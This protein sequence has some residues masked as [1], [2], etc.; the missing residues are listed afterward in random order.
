MTVVV[1]A[2]FVVVWFTRAGRDVRQAW[3]LF[4]QSLACKIAVPKER[5]YSVVLVV[6]LFHLQL[7]IDTSVTDKIQ[8]PQWGGLYV[9]S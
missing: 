8:V 4:R 3:T 2:P 7:R 1:V 9:S 5:V 6:S